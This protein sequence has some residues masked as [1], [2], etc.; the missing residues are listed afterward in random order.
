LKAG[1]METQQKLKPL[2]LGFTRRYLSIDLPEVRNSLAVLNAESGVYFSKTLDSAR[3][4]LITA[5]GVITEEIHTSD[6]GRVFDLIN[7]ATLRVKFHL[8]VALRTENLG[9]NKLPEEFVNLEIDFRDHTLTLQVAIAGWEKANAIAEV[10][11]KG[12]VMVTIDL[13]QQ[14]QYLEPLLESFLKD[15]PHTEKNVFLIMRFKNE[16]PFPDIVEAVRSTCAAKGLDVIRSD[17]KEYTD[18]LLDNVLTHMYA[19]DYAIAIF[20]EIN[21]RE[22]NP[23]VA[24]EVGFYVAKCKRVLILKDQAIASMPADIV[25]TSNK[26]FNTYDAKQ[27]IPPQVNKW[28]QDYGIGETGSAT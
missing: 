11:A 23:N 28:L 4:S 21:Y 14:H 15:H 22:F 27:T 18:D 19:C 9:L 13:P 6:T 20:D 1:E 7:E 3:Y 24:L 10:L 8:S 26:T 12:V 25:G 5:D 2:T 16:A 17:D